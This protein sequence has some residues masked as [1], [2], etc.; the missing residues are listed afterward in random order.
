M[1]PSVELTGFAE[2]PLAH[3]AREPGSVLD[4]SDP[5]FVVYHAPASDSADFGQVMRV[6]KSG[7]TVEISYTAP[8][9]FGAKAF[10]AGADIGLLGLDLLR[11]RVL[12]LDMRNGTL[13]V[14]P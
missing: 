5:R 3:V 14:A 12:T 7:G 6:R 1:K 13:T 10:A 4:A 8:A 11:D 9:P 2:A